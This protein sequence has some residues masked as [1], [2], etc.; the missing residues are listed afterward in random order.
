[1]SV[2]AVRHVG[3]VV[4]DLSRMLWFYRD[5]LGLTVRSHAAEAGAYLDAM[6][7][8][9]GARVTA[10]KLAAADGPTL[11]ELLAFEV[12]SLAA[13]SVRTTNAPGLTHVAFTVGDLAETHARL[14]AAG[15]RFNAP[16]QVS[17]D[18][19]ALVTYCRDPEGN[20]VELVEWRGHANGT[21][22]P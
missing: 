20:Y 15:I 10:V 2:Q 9:T 17:P 22:K 19:A 3:L 8:L 12:P 1:M 5:L 21:V 14:G 16:P 7:G 4:E 13:A 18:G 6:L 11:V